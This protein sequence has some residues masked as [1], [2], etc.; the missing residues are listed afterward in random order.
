MVTTRELLAHNRAREEVSAIAARVRAGEANRA[1][2]AVSKA[3]PV[4]PEASQPGAKK[5]PGGIILP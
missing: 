5:S 2:A 1:A 4:E 3:A